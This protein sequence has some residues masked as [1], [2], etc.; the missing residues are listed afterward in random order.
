MSPTTTAAKRAAIVGYAHS[1][2]T[3]TEEAGLG[4]LTIR[5][6]R[7]AVTDAGLDLDQ[8]DGFTTGALFPSASGRPLTDGVEIVTSDWVANQLRVEARWLCGFQ[9]IGQICGSVILAANAIS[10]GAA[11]YVVVHRAMYNPPGRYHTNQMTQAEG[12]AQWSAPHGFWGPPAQM[13]LPYM[14][15]MQRYGARRE[16]MATAVVGARAAG[17]KLPWSHWH[18]KPLTVDDYMDA[19]ML[20]DPMSVLDCDIPIN[21]VGAFVLTSAERAKDLYHPPV[22]V[23]GH[24]QG[25]RRPNNGI[26][27][28][29]LDDMI[30]G[31]QAVA[32]KLWASAGFGVNDVDVPQIYDG[33]TPFLYFWLESMGFC[34]IGEA[35]EYIQDP[36]I[37][38]GLP[39]KTGGGAVGSGR[40][41]GV[42]QMLECY[43]Q[44]SRR[45]GARQLEQADTAFACQ[46]SPN[47]GGVV[48]YASEAAI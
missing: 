34:G 7:E 29:S 36:T 30:A 8:I 1:A 24:A 17:S 2:I 4:A 28:W 42:P 12:A 15:Y 6:I 48:A 32:K 19:R 9:G 23:A 37:S 5:T 38:P 11:D 25:H 13:A 18:N 46:A 22:Y 27:M 14:E 3:R 20:A 21:G 26:D 16:H 44:L 45:A 40:M 10:S 43:L 41:H 31:G 39:F 35:F 33:F 47:V